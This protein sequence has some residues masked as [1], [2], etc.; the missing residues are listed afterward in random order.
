MPSS[1]VIGAT[2]LH[3]TVWWLGGLAVRA[4]DLRLSSCEFEFHKPLVLPGSNIGQV[5]HTY[6]PSRSQWSSAG[7]P[8]CGWET[9]I[10][11]LIT[12]TTVIR[13]LFGMGC[14][15]F[16]AVPRS[17]QPS[18]P[19]GTVKWVLVIAVSKVGRITSVGWQVTLCDP[20]WQVIS[21]MR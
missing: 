1:F 17:T 7:V 10:S 8:G 18:T 21:Q 19:C 13:S 6:W 3:C 16:P 4:F 2:W 15:T 14:S 12:T 20:I 5:T 9:A 11:A